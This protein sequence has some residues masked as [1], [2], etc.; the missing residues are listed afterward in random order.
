MG[1]FSYYKRLRSVTGSYKLLRGIMDVSRKQS[2]QLT[3]GNTL[4]RTSIVLSV[5]VARFGC[6]AL[7]EHPEEVSWKP[8]HPSSWRIPQTVRLIAA[9]HA[10][11]TRIDQ[12]TCGALSM[13]PTRLM[14]VNL[15]TFE[16]RRRQLPNAGRCPHGRKGHVSVLQGLDEN[17]KFKTPPP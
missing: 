15:D 2:N 16:E 6:A 1:F 3:V 8:D 4:Y 17:G 9:G 5:A 10:R 11:S 7:I 14:H 13:K 12:C